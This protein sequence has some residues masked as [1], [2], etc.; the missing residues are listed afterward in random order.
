MHPFSFPWKHPQ[1]VNGFLM[2]WG[3]RLGTDALGTDGLKVYL[4]AKAYLS[5][6]CIKHSEWDK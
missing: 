3:G 5:I 2:F 4:I 1:N 6:N